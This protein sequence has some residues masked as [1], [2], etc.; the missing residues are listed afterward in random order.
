MKE[1]LYR[2]A[3]SH[4]W[5][6]AWQ[7]KLLWVFGLFAAF[8]G[9]MGLMDLLSKVGSAATNFGFFPYWLTLPRVARESAAVSSFTLSYDIWVWFVWLLVVLLGLGL[10]LIFVSVVSQ[11]ALIRAAANSAKHKKLP[12]V[13]EAWQAGT[14]HFWRLFFINLL[15]KAIFVL[16]ALF[17]GWATVA[18]ILEASVLEIGIFLLLFILAT[19]VG[20]VVSFLAV[21]AAAYVIVEEYSFGKAL[22]AAWHLFTSHWLVS[23]EVGLVVL[24][25]NVVLAAITVFGFLVF[26]FPTLLMWFVAALI[27]SAALWL[28]GVVVGLVLFLLFILCIGA[29]FSV[30]TTSVW[31]YLFMKM[32]HEGVKSRILHL[33]GR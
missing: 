3:L 9:Q 32:H 12:D 20:M 33:L 6:L 29:I 21:Y 15:K 31:T 7:H 24:V 28:A 17:V 25:L 10:L 26:F 30:F 13:G 14:K 5:A 11:G 16:L 1:P 27:G 22:S 8:L 2:Q 4:S 18:V 23:F 19:L